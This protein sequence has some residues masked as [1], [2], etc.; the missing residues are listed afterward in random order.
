MERRLTSAESGALYAPP[1]Y[2][3]F[4]REGALTAQAFDD[5]SLQL[6]GE[7]VPV[8]ERVGRMGGAGP[9]RDAL[10]S[11]SSN[12]V[13]AY[14]AVAGELAARLVRPPRSGP[15]DDFAG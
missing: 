5:G 12:G 3:L 9:T 8:A 14:G 11:A 4:V 15:R 6:T 13:L 10:F 7:P 1:G 2:L